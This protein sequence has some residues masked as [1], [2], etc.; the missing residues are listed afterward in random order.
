MGCLI[1]RDKIIG[2]ACKH[3]VFFPPCYQCENQAL[4]DE[5]AAVKAANDGMV[6][7]L[8]NVSSACIGEI[9]M[10]YRLDAQAIGQMI[11]ESVGMTHPEMMEYVKNQVEK[12]Q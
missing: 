6:E 5:L 1:M 2:E 8:T 11:F 12:G 7:V 4:R 9:A 10:G 3:G